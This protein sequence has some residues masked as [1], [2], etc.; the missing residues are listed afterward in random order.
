MCDGAFVRGASTGTFR[1][2]IAA[3]IFQ[4]LYGVTI[5]DVTVQHSFDSLFPH[6]W[7]AGGGASRKDPTRKHG[8]PKATKGQCGQIDNAAPV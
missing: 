8:G 2:E 6:V 1:N 3:A 5:C 4:L 7:A